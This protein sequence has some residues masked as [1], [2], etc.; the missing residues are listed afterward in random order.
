M[1]VF[2]LG[3]QISQY[4][5]NIAGARPAVLL[6][7]IPYPVLDFYRQSPSCLF[8]AVDKH[9]SAYVLLLEHY[10]VY[11]GHAS[12]AVAEYEHVPCLFQSRFASE[13]KMQEPCNELFIDSPFPC[14]VYACIYF[15]KRGVCRNES[16]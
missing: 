5:E 13:V 6:N 11:E 7:C 4:R 10:H 16:F 9:V 8:P 12:G 2:G 15:C 3:G 14:T 1:P